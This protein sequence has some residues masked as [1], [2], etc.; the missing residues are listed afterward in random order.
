MQLLFLLGAYSLGTNS[1]FSGEIVRRLEKRWKNNKRA[2]E[3]TK[4]EPQVLR[5]VSYFSF[6]IVPSKWYIKDVIEEKI[7][8]E[9]RSIK[10]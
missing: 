9:G 3:G 10:A 1:F 5:L 6:K 2:S 7:A 4:K 8:A